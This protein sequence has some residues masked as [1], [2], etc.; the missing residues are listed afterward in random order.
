MVADGGYAAIELNAETLPWAP[1]HIT[2]EADQQTRR[3]VAGACQ[4]RGLTI[5]AVGAHIPMVARNIATR[6]SAIAFVNGCT[7]L[8]RDVRAPV[9]HILSGPL[10]DGADRE[11][12]WNWFRAAV[13]ET[14]AYASARNVTLGIEAIAGHV[15]HKVDD[16]HRLRRE[17]PGVPFKVNFDPSHLQVQGES[18]LRV[19]DEL[20]D[21][22]VH[23]HLK[24]GSGHFPSFKFPP[25]G[26]GDIDFVRLV[27][28][29]RSIAYAGAL[30]VE[31]EAQ[32]YG[33]HET[34]YQILREG[35]VFVDRL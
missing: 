3:E 32:V 30:S 25:L 7:D 35:K 23:V 8:A 20:G 1:A 5:P 34:E 11:E 28:R 21:Q 31:Y 33:Y 6:V 29:L 19:V 24:D 12:A 16:Y 4:A 15:F 27:E 18:P 14:T 17:L 13:E 22:I 9:V 10:D 2:P 26:R